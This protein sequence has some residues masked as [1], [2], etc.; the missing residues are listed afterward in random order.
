M[1]I[2]IYTW[3]LQQNLCLLVCVDEHA[4]NLHSWKIQICILPCFLRPQWAFWEGCGF[5]LCAHFFQGL[6]SGFW[7]EHG[8]TTISLEKA[9]K[10]PIPA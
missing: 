2:Y 10:F 8:G 7:E 4:Y 9:M 1:S 5:S 6:G 3:I